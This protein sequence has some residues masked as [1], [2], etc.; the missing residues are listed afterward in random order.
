MYLQN[1]FVFLAYKVL[2]LFLCLWGLYLNS[3]LPQGTIQWHVLDYYTIQSNILC[4]LYFAWS[5]YK[6]L[7]EGE[8][9]GRVYTPAPR[10]K[11]AI[12]FCITVTMLIYHFILV[13]VQFSMGNAAIVYSTG[14]IL[15]HYVVPGMVILDWIL[16][17]KKGRWK[18]YDPFLWLVIPYVYF[19]FAI[20]RAH[21]RGN[22]P[23]TQSRY[24]YG[25]I[26]IDQYG[27]EQVLMN[28]GKLTLVF[29]LI[30]FLY[31]CMDRLLS[32]LY[33]TD[34]RTKIRAYF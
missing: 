22:I 17:D 15:V 20:V 16:F 24:P 31:V 9:T 19:V 3:G 13:P 18:I 2:F 8:E 1:R 25:F 4:L 28:A 7:R 30:G 6:N 26:N 21:F 10:L 5:F 29:L 11:G 14:N 33:H 27:W 32:R 23:G 34:K 12:T